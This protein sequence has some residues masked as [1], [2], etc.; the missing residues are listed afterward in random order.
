MIFV[1]S[2]VAGLLAVIV[3]GALVFVIGISVLVVLSIMSKDQE[4]AIGFDFVAFGRS[5]LAFAI[6]VLAFI[7]GFVWEYLRISRA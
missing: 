5:A 7:T 2:L 6:G 4:S 1:K 3:A